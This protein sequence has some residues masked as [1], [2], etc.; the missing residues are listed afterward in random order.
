MIKAVMKSVLT[1]ACLTVIASLPPLT[2]RM[3]A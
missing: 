1:A 3:R 2:R